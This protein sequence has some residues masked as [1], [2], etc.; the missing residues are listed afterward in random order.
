MAGTNS[1]R[2]FFKKLL[3]QRNAKIK[4]KRNGVVT[5]PWRLRLQ[6]NPDHKKFSSL[7]NTVVV[8]FFNIFTHGDVID[9]QTWGVSPQKNPVEPP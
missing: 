9:A 8:I 4:K 1:L 6:Q 3:V 7:Y 5:L 2:R